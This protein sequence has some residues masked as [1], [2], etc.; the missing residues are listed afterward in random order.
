MT[1]TV[2]L[3]ALFGKREAELS[4]GFYRR[5][6]VVR[7]ANR[8][9]Y[10]TLA[11]SETPSLGMGMVQ[12]VLAVLTIHVASFAW[13]AQGQVGSAVL[14]STSKRP[15]N[16]YTYQFSWDERDPENPLYGGFEKGLTYQLVVL[17]IITC[18][19]GGVYQRSERCSEVVE[20]WFELVRA[21][22][23]GYPRTSEGGW[24]ERVIEAACRD[25]RIQPFIERMCDALWFAMCPI[26]KKKTND[27]MPTRPL[28]LDEEMA[29]P[30]SDLRTQRQ[31]Q[32]LREAIIP[33][34]CLAELRR[35]AASGEDIQATL[36]NIEGLPEEVQALISLG[37]ASLNGG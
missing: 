12:A 36:K 32:A 26:A 29:L 6:A 22:D 10:N 8:S 23:A 33:Y 20:R 4:S 17:H 34:L 19:L 35:L 37:A 27:T 1:Q 30:P 3:S 9:R 7:L 25:P 24:S 31:I 13:D 14:Y 5:G 11:A 28:F 18:C 16:Q 15:K 21:C 2:S